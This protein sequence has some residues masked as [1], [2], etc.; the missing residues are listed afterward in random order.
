MTLIH[1]AVAVATMLICM[2]QKTASLLIASSY[3]GGACQAQKV[4]ACTAV[5]TVNVPGKLLSSSRKAAMSN[6]AKTAA[7]MT[8]WMMR[9][10]NNADPSAQKGLM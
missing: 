4:M 10:V 5:H 2:S 7:S 3:N 8:S 6:G 9:T 1:Q